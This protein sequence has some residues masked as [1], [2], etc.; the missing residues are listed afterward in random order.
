MGEEYRAHWRD[1]FKIL[2]ESPEQRHDSKYLSGNERS[3]SKRILW[4]Y[5]AKVWTGFTWL[6]IGTGGGLL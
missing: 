5:G 3:I 4:K 2:I 6:R 1:E